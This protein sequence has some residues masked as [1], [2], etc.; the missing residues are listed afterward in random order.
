ML[1]ISRFSFL[2]NNHDTA[3]RELQMAIS[4]HID[5]CHARQ[6]WMRQGVHGPGPRRAA[7]EVA[8]ELEPEFKQC[9]DGRGGIDVQVRGLV[10]ATL[11]ERADLVAFTKCGCAGIGRVLQQVVDGLFD[12]AIEPV[13]LKRVKLRCSNLQHGFRASVPRAMSILSQGNL[14]TASCRGG[15]PAGVNIVGN[16]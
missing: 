1:Y 2:V 10:Y 14:L 9:G 6:V 3:A 16:V 13:F 12:E 5:L 7:F 4:N 11:H 8:A 15:V